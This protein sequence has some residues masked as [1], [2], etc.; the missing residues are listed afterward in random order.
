MA[1]SAHGEVGSMN[2]LEARRRLVQTRQETGSFSETARRWSS[3]RH[4]VRKWVRRRS[5]KG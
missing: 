2:R 5:L 4:L 3:S 1:E